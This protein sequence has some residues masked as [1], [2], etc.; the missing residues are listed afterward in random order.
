MKPRTKLERAVL[1]E[2]A[3]ILWDELDVDA[4]GELLALGRWGY[5]VERQAAKRLRSK[6]LLDD[7]GGMTE[8]G[9]AAYLAGRRATASLTRI[10]VEAK[11]G[12]PIAEG[13]A[14]LWHERRAASESALL[15]AAVATKKS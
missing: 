15:S 13:A 14:V 12:G 9:H 2:L 8:V 10:F 5:A 3:K 4:A 11:A 6:G 1:W 7:Q